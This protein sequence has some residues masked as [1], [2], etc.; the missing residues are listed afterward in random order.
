MSKKYVN[1]YGPG[2]PRLFSR[3]AVANVSTGELMTKWYAITKTDL[4]RYTAEYK[5]SGTAA[6]GARASTAT[7][8]ALSKK[9][10]SDYIRYAIAQDLHGAA[11]AAAPRST[12][13]F[14]QVVETE[15]A[16]GWFGKT[17][18][19]RVVRGGL[20]VVD[21]RAINAIVR[22]NAEVAATFGLT[23]G[24]NNLGP[25]IDINKAKEKILQEETAG[26]VKENVGR[27]AGGRR[28]KSGRKTRKGKGKGRK[29][30]K[31]KGSRRH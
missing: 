19:T 7:L 28:R 22:D 11:S 23:E 1:A 12:G 18:T 30:R 6:T 21:E 8:E 25:I 14:S 20:S 24:G 10:F 31:A 15:E 16:E 17:I 4:D 13:E 26:N 9:V 27:F 29:T 3:A 2:D 5:R